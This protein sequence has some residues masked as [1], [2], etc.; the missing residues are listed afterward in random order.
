MH[1]CWWKDVIICSDPVAQSANLRLSVWM[2]ENVG[3]VISESR[4][5]DDFRVEVLTLLKCKIC[6][7]EYCNGLCTFDQPQ[8]SDLFKAF[9]TGAF[10]HSCTKI[11]MHLNVNTLIYTWT[12][13]ACPVVSVH[14]CLFHVI[15]FFYCFYFSVS[16]RCHGVHKF[17]MNLVLSCAPS[18]LKH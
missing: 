6:F 5:L 9:S 8:D 3:N 12:R 7:L 13:V 2:T 11:T 4:M 10:Y 18:S 1:H 14:Y 16:F 17:S 15:M